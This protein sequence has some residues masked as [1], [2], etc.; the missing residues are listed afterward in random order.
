MPGSANRV[1]AVWY[2]ATSFTVDVNLAD[3]QAHDLELY[4]DDWDNRGRSEQVQ[5]SDAA[6]GAV[7]GTETISS[8]GSG[9]Y[10][11]WKVSGNVVIT[12]TRQ[13]G[14]NAVLNGLFLEPTSSLPPI[15]TASFLRQDA[16]T[17]GSWIGSYGA[18]GYEIVS[19]P[20]SL[21]A[22]DTI[23]PSGQ[24]TW[25]WTTTSTDPRALQVPG[26]SSRVAAVWYS[27]TSFSVDVNLGDGQTHDL[28]LYF[29]DWDNKGRSEQVQLS[30]TATGTVLITQ[31]ISS[32]QNGVYL[33]Y[34]VA[35]NIT[36]TITRTGGANA[37]LSG[38][39]LDPSSA[40][41]ASA[42][43]L[44][45]GV[46]SQGRGI[47]AEDPPVID[48]I[49]T[50]DF[51]S[52]DTTVPPAMNSARGLLHDLALAQVGSRNRP[53]GCTRSLGRRPVG[54]R[55]STRLDRGRGI[56]GSPTTQPAS[57]DGG[58]RPAPEPIPA[59]PRL[60]LLIVGRHRQSPSGGASTIR[61]QS[62]SDLRNVRP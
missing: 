39:F 55:Q 49:G 37:V 58:H 4:F 11:D 3:G 25:T 41:G 61:G 16:T 6:T 44:G 62:G 32:F 50:L 43:L 12:I 1:A 20:S 7:L 36:I 46:G 18:Q 26:S 57:L 23:T 10:L 5:I 48:A 14:V 47:G 28:E 30:D 2:S 8:F 38:L 53:R 35:G 21:P 60:R 40:S 22:N 51:G 17:Q 34:T 45:R 29:L 24:S 54:C 19:G 56:Y 59:R 31:S 33:D 42:A 13:A 9:V 27:A 15:A 52:G